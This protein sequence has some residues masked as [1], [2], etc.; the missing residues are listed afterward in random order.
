MDYREARAYI[1]E[2]Q[3]YGGEMSLGPI[4]A[5]LEELGHPE[6]CLRF[7]HIAG[8][9]GKGSILSYIFHSAYPR[10]LPGGSLYIPYFVQL[11]GRF[12]VN[13]SFISREEY[14]EFAERIRQAVENIAERGRQEALS[15]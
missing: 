14:V 12:Q 7:I 2:Q 8:T 10:G 1:E 6:R 13:G 9:N 4:R 11:P 15:L 3:R 5:L